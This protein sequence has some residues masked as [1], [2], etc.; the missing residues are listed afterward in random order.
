MTPR[1][2]V[3]TTLTMERA[4]SGLPVPSGS[5]TF[6]GAD[7]HSFTRPGPRLHLTKDLQSRV[8][9]ALFYITNS[10]NYPHHRL[11]R[12]TRKTYPNSTAANY[13]YD[14]DSHLTLVSN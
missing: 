14:N 2:G 5:P 4:F 12:P 10:L 13:T 9:R 1:V 7:Q 11:N 6:F 8:F 3:K